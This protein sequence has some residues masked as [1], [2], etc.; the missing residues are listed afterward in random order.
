MI[1]KKSFLFLIN[2][3]VATLVNYVTLVILV[4]YFFISYAGVAALISAVVGILVS[5]VGSRYLVFESSAPILSEFLRFKTLY[6]SIAT[7][8]ALT[9]FIWADVF[10]LSYTLGFVLITLISVV[11][12]YI[13]NQ[14]FVFK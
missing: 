10:L 5:F 3:I 11:F 7:F 4:D 12:S 8:Q 6:V 1:P 9:M 2:G 13:G 14:L